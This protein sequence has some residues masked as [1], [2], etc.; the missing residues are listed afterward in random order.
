MRDAFNGH[1]DK[2]MRLC[3]AAL[4]FCSPIRKIAQRSFELV[5]PS[6]KSTKPFLRE[7]FSNPGNFSIAPAE[8]RDSIFRIPRKFLYL[9]YIPKI[10]DQELKLVRQDQRFSLISSTLD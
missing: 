8:I 2:D 7:V 1:P 4:S 5:L 6:G 3:I 10:R 9:E